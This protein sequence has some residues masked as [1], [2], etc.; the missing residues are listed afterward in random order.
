MMKEVDGAL[1]TQKTGT[2]CDLSHR[3]ETR[4]AGEVPA[5]QRPPKAEP[6][7]GEHNHTKEWVGMKGGDCVGSS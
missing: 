7:W 2:H 6:G 1:A 3:W 5:K 4:D